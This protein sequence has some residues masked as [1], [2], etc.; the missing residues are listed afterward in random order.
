MSIFVARA[1]RSKT[2]DLKH[3]NHVL[4][5]KI[6]IVVEGLILSPGFASRHPSYDVGLY[7]YP[8]KQFLL[9][10]KQSSLYSGV[11]S[12]S[13]ALENQPVLLGVPV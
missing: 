10:A 5:F 4:K 12:I 6:V 3:F 13:F 2:R 9:F 1:Q 7:F 11:L 8:Q